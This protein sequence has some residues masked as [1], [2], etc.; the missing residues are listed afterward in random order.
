MAKTKTRWRTRTKKTYRKARGFGGGHKEVIDGVVVGVAQGFVPDGALYG[1][2]D[3]LI[4][5]GVGYFRHNP[6]LKTLGGYQ[7]GLKLPALLGQRQGTQLG[8]PSQV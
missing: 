2:A 4:M 8:A 1:L 3:P 7:L 5:L 6:T